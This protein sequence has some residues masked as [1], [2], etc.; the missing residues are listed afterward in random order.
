MLYVRFWISMFDLCSPVLCL[1]FKIIATGNIICWF[2][3][4]YPSMSCFTL[5]LKFNRRLA[6]VHIVHNWTIL[7]THSFKNCLIFRLKARCLSCPVC[8]GYCGL[9]IS[10]FFYCHFYTFT[11]VKPEYCRTNVPCFA[12]IFPVERSDQCWHGCERRGTLLWQTVWP[13]T[14]V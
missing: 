2:L 9:C 13:G 1:G 12:T 4:Q 11:Q 3:S 10:T 5:W 6:F 8:T 14:T 7:Y